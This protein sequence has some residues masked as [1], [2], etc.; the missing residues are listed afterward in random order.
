[1]IVI[2]R[3]QFKQDVTGY[4]GKLRNHLYLLD[5][6][7]RK[8]DPLTSGDYDEGAPAFSPDGKTIAFVSKSGAKDLDRTDAWQLFA[9]EA[10]SGATPRALTHD[11]F[12]NNPPEAHSPLAWSP[13]GR[14]IAYVQ[15]GPDKMIYYGLN[16]LAVVPAAGGAP[17][18]V[19]A[20]TDLNA[21]NP[22]FT[23]DGAS[24]LFTLEEDQAVH[25]AK[26]PFAGGA[27][28]RLV[29]GRVVVGDFSMAVNGRI[30]A[31]IGNSAAPNEIY[32][33]DGAAPRPLSRQ[34]DAWLAQIKLGAVQETKFRSKDGTEIHG[35]LTLP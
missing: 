21:L 8:V 14:W 16:K 9:I 24:I 33:V 19:T 23:K 22:Q 1:P 18:I 4:L 35:F 25:L 5:L 13:D 34:N 10:R 30:A 27:I 29:G 17:R 12:A 26:I 28:E 20:G 15:G 31:R 3:F 6:A 7:T 11:E 32:A 2:D